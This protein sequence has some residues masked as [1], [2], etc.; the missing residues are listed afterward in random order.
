MD[1]HEL[2]ER[3]KDQD[4]RAT[5]D[6]FIMIGLILLLIGVWLGVFYNIS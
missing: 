3:M 6:F 1:Q 2:N 5:R 4:R